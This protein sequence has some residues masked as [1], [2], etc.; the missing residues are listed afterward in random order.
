MS[1]KYTVTEVSS[2]TNDWTSPKDGGV[3]RYFKFRFTDSNG[4]EGEGSFGRRVRDDGTVAAP[5]APGFE[6]YGNAKYDEQYGTWKF[7]GVKTPEQFEK[8][9]AGGGSSN[10]T[11]NFQVRAGGDDKMRS[12]EQC[13][14]GEAIIAAATLA[15]SPT[16]AMAYAD[17]FFD[18]ISQGN[19]VTNNGP[20]ASW[21]PDAPPVPSTDQIPF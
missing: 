11:G 4:G 8:Y 9:G 18:Y 19:V 7:T 17:K 15:K 21:S 6:F 20:D 13:M 16:E 10:G 12:K 2:D 5:P 1:L 3:T 14:R